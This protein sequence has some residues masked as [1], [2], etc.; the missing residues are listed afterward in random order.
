[1]GV[2]IFGKHPGTQQALRQLVAENREQLEEEDNADVR[3][4]LV[5]LLD[6]FT[7]K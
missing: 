1:M 5:K 6:G 4:Q 7:T 3:R 2:W